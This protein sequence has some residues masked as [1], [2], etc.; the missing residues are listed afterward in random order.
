MQSHLKS[1]SIL[2]LTVC[3]LGNQTAVVVSQPKVVASQI[4]AAAS[5]YPR[6]SFPALKD[7]VSPGSS[8]YQFR[9]QL[10]RAIQNRDAKYI[11]AIA[12]PQIKLSFGRD[13]KISALGLSNP[14]SLS[15]KHLEQV[16]SIGCGH[17]V[18]SPSVEIEAYKCPYLYQELKTNPYDIY[19]IGENINVRSQPQTDS[20]VIGTLTNEIVKS[21]SS[22]F[23]RLIQQQR[24]A[25]DTFD[26]WQPIITP[27]GKQGY[28]S[29]RYAYFSAG[30]RAWFEKK[31]GEWK[32]TLFLGG[33]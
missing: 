16:M 15:W 21:D 31:K 25:T 30:Y 22:G 3:L 17:N 33:D 7:Q 28:V 18:D 29:S 14:K 5:P 19:I 26:G 23:Q 6:R 9:Q 8:F 24:E 20:P 10:K 32:M 2:F 12:D 4:I 1:K 13:I 27:E 11:Q